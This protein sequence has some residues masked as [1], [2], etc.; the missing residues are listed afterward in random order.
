MSTSISA[1]LDDNILKE[2]RDAI[3]HK[4]GL[5]RGDFKKNIETAMIEYIIKYS[6][7]ENAKDFAKRA[8][9]IRQ[10]AL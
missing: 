3:Y 10:G 7:S 5:M 8:I 2:F 4:S 9:S 1:N 6:E